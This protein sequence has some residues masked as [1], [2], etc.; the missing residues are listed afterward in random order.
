MMIFPAIDIKDG[1]VVRLAR[2]K[3][4]QVTEYDLD[5]PA[6]VRRWRDLG[7]QWLHVVDLDGALN[8]RIINW[9]TIEAI[10]ESVSIPI[11][12]G[13]GIRFAEDISRLMCMGAR[14]VILG[15]KAIID[16]DFLKQMIKVWGDQIAVS[17]DAANGRVTKLGWTETT[18]IKAVDFAKNMQDLGLKCLI[19][20]DIARDGMLTGPNLESLEEILDAVDIPVISSGGISNIDD[21]KHL[22]AFESKGLA[23]VIIG[24][25][26]YEGTLDLKD[27]LAL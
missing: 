6:V 10:L 17:V 4:D 13:G 25:A 8:G 24:K 9:D 16:P 27:A 20:T 26:L 18:D 2:G 15:T 12:I 21:L 19:F 11:Q 5:P 22:K 1:K 7:A 14:R 23:G 3:F